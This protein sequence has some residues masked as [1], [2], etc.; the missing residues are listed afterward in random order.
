MQTLEREAMLICEICKGK[1]NNL[2]TSLQ[3]FY[4]I[5]KLL[6]N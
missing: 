1:P 5:V 2:H 4:K 6:N 3:S